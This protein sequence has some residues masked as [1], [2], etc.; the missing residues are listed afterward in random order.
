MVILSGGVGA[1]T[2]VEQRVRQVQDQHRQAHTDDEDEHD[3]A[4]KIV[5][6]VADAQ[7]EQSTNTGVGEDLLDQHSARNDLAKG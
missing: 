1:D 4:K 2:R 7:R 6:G 5:V 3:A